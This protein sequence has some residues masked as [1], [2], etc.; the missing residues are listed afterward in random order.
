ML[1]RCACGR[2]H[3]ADTTPAGRDLSIVVC[4]VDISSLPPEQARLSGAPRLSQL[5]P[6]LEPSAEEQLEQPALSA[7]APRH[8]VAVQP[9][10]G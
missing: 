3:L 5:G 2:F 1:R 7:Q 4:S 9:A 10:A 8:V 6:A